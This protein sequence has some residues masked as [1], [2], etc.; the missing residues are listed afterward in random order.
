MILSYNK[1]II[2]P[3]FKKIENDNKLIDNNYYHKNIK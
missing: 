1:Y 3:I 2:S